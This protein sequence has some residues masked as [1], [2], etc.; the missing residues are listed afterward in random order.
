MAWGRARFDAGNTGEY[1]EGGSDPIVVTADRTW[2]GGEPVNNDIIVRSGTLT[3][4]Y[5]EYQIRPGCK[6]IVMDGGTLNV[7]GGVL[8]DANILVKSGGAMVID[9]NGVIYLEDHGDVKLESGAVLDFIT[10]D[11]FPLDWWE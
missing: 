4:P 3:F 10:G 1:V 5:G 11:I 9:N 6:I 7:Y 2:P 8:L